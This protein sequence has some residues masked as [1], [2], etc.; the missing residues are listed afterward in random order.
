MNYRSSFSEG[1]ARAI[2]AD[3]YL[4]IN[5]EVIFIKLLIY[6]LFILSNIPHKNFFFHFSG[7][8]FNFCLNKLIS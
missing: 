7:K 8:Q 4:N 5:V 3:A 1:L 6:E 2:K